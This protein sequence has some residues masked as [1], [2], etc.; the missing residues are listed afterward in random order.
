M[1]KFLSRKFIFT[2]I[3]DLTGLL[4]M[5]I[6]NDTITTI[7][8]AALMLVATVVFCIVEGTIDAKSI[9]AIS[10]A[11]EDIAE[12]LGAGDEIVDA[13]DKVGDIVEDLVDGNGGEASVDEGK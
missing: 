4:T 5:V 13:I 3:A 1:K 12:S 11:V 2:A 9:G 8:G 7:I 10:D 6:S